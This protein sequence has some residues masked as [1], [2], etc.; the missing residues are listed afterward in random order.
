MHPR[1]T[2]ALFGVDKVRPDLPGEDK[3]SADFDLKPIR[4]AVAMLMGA[5]TTRG[6]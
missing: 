1:L 4:K 5:T 2:R 3:V 6:Q